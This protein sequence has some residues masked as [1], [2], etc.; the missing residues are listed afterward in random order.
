MTVGTY[1]LDV[2]YLSYIGFFLLYLYWRRMIPILF[3][4]SFSFF[5][6]LFS[7][8]FFLQLGLDNTHH[9]TDHTLSANEKHYMHISRG[10]ET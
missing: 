3:F 1:D 7:L 6:F 5:F 4:F 2:L 8:L 9:G 10:R